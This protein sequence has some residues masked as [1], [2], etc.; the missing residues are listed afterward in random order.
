MNNGEHG[1]RLY[2]TGNTV[3]YNDFINNNNQYNPYYESI[4]LN[5]DPASP[6]VRDN[7]WDDWISPDTDTDGIVDE[8][9]VINSPR[10][11]VLIDA[12]PRTL[13]NNPQT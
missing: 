1:V 12:R 10:Q 7:F 8:P 6:D 9:Y 13:P 4:Q 11:S 3:I 5:P 2:G